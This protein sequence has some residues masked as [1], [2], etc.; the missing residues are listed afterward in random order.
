M[1]F[2]FVLL[3]Q[4]QLAV[5]ALFRVPHSRARYLMGSW[6]YSLTSVDAWLGWGNRLI[7]ISNCDLFISQSAESNGVP[8]PLPGGW[9]GAGPL[10]AMS[11]RGGLFF[12]GKL[13]QAPAPTLGGVSR[14]KDTNDLIF[15]HWTI[16][17]CFVVTIRLRWSIDQGQKQNILPSTCRNYNYVPWGDWSMVLPSV[18][19]NDGRA[20]LRPRIRWFMICLPGAGVPPAAI[21]Q[22]MPT[23][24]AMPQKLFWLKDVANRLF[25]C[26]FDKL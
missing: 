20:R 26:F 14:C 12:W 3:K 15:V 4:V 8:F 5:A 24:G 9:G 18:Q 10:W 23:L 16:C 25:L 13:N 21:K 19:E 1:K 6:S 17:A 22:V 7:L 11:E 2:F